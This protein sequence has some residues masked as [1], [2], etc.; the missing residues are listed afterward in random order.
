MK[1]TLVAI[2]FLFAFVS[3]SAQRIILP[4]G[5]YMDT[6][7]V[8]NSSCPEGYP[9]YYSVRGKYLKSSFTLLKDVNT[10][11]LI[12]HAAYTGNGYITFR[13]V[14]DCQGKML[15]KVRVMQTDE[16]YRLF[17][18]DKSLVEEL[19]SY[20]LTLKDWKIAKHDSSSVSYMSYL[21]FKINNGKI[22]NIIP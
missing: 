22:I 3:V 14:V 16:K 6:T 21:S 19:Y 5:E 9:Y 15:P 8:Q 7:N 20:L 2:C 13:F 17:H 1:R 12:K 11:L 18:F 10:F 4:K